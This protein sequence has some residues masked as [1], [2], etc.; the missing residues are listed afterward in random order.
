MSRFASFLFV[1]LLA[2]P[3]ARAQWTPLPIPYQQTFGGQTFTLEADAYALGVLGGRLVA[4]AQTPGP[5]DPRF[6]VGLVTRDD[7]NGRWTSTIGP[8]YSTPPFPA[9]A[10][11][12]Q[13]LDGPDYTSRGVFVGSDGA[14]FYR[15]T[16]EGAT[17]TRITPAQGLPA[18]YPDVGT[19]AGNRNRIK[20]VGEAGGMLW[21]TAYDGLY[22]SADGLTWTKVTAGLPPFKNQIGASFTGWDDAIVHTV[23]E[24]GGA[25]FAAIARGIPSTKTRGGL[26]RSTDGGTTWARVSGG[27]PDSADVYTFFRAGTRLLASTNLN[28]ASTLNGYASVLYAS[29]DGGNTWTPAPTQPNAVTGLGGCPYRMRRVGTA[30]VAGCYGPVRPSNGGVWVSLDEGAT[31]TDVSGNLPRRVQQGNAVDGVAV[32]DLMVFGTDLYVIQN[33]DNADG[34]PAS[35]WRRPLAGLG[36]TTAAERV[37]EGIGLRLDTP[38][39]NPARE[40]VTV[41]FHVPPGPARLAVYDALGREVAVLHD[42]PSSGEGTAS[43]DV[44]ALAPGVYLARLITPAGLVTRRLVVAR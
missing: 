29:T 32:A 13:Y 36:I 17:W 41:R 10:F 34:D 18:S 20:L 16:D 21:V 19:G 22:R 8:R 1:L 33:T 9:A 40:A 44:S 38:V 4:T 25:L 35:V 15:T 42:G 2:A 39:P 24:E 23:A 14:G 30:I 6:L 27:L 37:D 7:A 12:A 28:T 43:L 5:S 26:Y 11:D 3:A 31:W